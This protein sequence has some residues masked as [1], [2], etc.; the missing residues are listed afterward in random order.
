MVTN[1]PDMP[2]NNLPDDT[3]IASANAYYANEGAELPARPT[4]CPECGNDLPEDFDLDAEHK[5]ANNGVLLVGCE[6]YHVQNPAAFG[7]PDPTWQDWQQEPNSSDVDVI[8]ARHPEHGLVIDGVVALF[9]EDAA[10]ACISMPEW[11]PPAPLETT[12][13]TAGEDEG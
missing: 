8:V 5:Y 7:H 13:N 9:D 12:P 3:Y 4:F 1:L 10:R 6:G 2:P 11:G